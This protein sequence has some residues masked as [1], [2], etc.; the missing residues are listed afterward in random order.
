MPAAIDSFTIEG[1]F[2]CKTRVEDV[3]QITVANAV[4]SLVFTDESN[5]VFSGTVAGQIIRLPV[6]NGVDALAVGHFFFFNNNAS[7]TVAIQNSASGALLTL[8]PGF[9]ARVKLLT[10][11]TAAGT[12]D[13]STISFAAPVATGSAN[14]IGSAL[15][16]VRSDHVHETVIPNLFASSVSA[17]TTTSATDVLLTGMTATAAVSGTYAVIFNSTWSVNN[18]AA[19]TASATIYN[20]AVAVANSLRREGNVTT[21]GAF[22]TLSTV[23]VISV[24]A[25]QVVEVRVNG[26]NGSTYTFN[27][28]SLTLIRLGP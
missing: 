17:F 18:T 28:R 14:A 13:I 12:W 2:R 4:T 10:N 1:Q 6:A 19:R 24:V 22:R 15:T 11:T 5:I 8:Q 26:T 21:S 9:S 16:L 3:L 25:G 27:E 20:N 7:V 23:T